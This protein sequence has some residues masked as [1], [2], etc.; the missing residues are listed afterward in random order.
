M[1]VL[2]KVQT[3]KTFKKMNL[4]FQN[5]SYK[6]KLRESTSSNCQ[7]RVCFFFLE[8]MF[9]IPWVDEEY[10]PDYLGLHQSPMISQCLTFQIM[11]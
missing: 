4:N 3:F 8:T 6:S 2:D 11:I 7:A 1:L 9:L 5:M 10:L